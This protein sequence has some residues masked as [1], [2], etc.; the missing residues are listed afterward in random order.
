MRKRKTNW[1]FLI[2]LAILILAVESVGMTTFSIIDWFWNTGYTTGYQG[3]KGRFAGVR[4]PDQYGGTGPPTY[5]EWTQKASYFSW[6]LD[7]PHM[8]LPDIIGEMSSIFIPSETIGESPSWIPDWLIRKATTVTNP[9]YVYDEWQFEEET[10]FT[11]YR[12]ENWR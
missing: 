2:V 7:A 12:M 6:D 10:E 8:Q 3:A 5:Y 9:R 4:L 11:F 1:N